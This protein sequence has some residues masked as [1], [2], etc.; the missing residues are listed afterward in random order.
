VAD[1]A[2]QVAAGMKARTSSRIGDTIDVH[3]TGDAEATVV[4]GDKTAAHHA[5][6]VEFGTID[7]AADPF[8]V[9]AAEEAR[10]RLTAAVAKVLS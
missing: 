2:D 6:F 5:G 3:R 7:M 8:A 10:H 9:P 4:A 1:V